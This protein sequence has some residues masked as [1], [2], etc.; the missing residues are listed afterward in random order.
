[1]ASTAFWVNA[2]AETSVGTATLAASTDTFTLTAHGLTNL[3]EVRVKSLTGGAVGVLIENAPYYVRNAAAN[4]FQ[5]AP[6]LGGPIMEFTSDGGAAV[7]RSQPVYSSQPVRRGDSG[8]LQRGNVAGGF[9]ARGGVFPQGSE[10]GHVGVSGTTWTVG[11]LVGVVS[12]A[13]GPYRVVHES[14]SNSL[15]P[16]DGTNPRLDALDLQVQDDDADGSGFHR[17]RVVYVVGTPA[18]S[19]SAPTQT[20]NSERLATILVP[21]GGSPVPSIASGPKFTTARGGIIPIL[22]STGRPTSGGLYKGLSVWDI[23]LKR[24]DINTDAGSTWE[25]LASTAG[26]TMLTGLMGRNYAHTAA[27]VTHTSDT[28]TALTG[29]P[30][31][32][33]TIP[34]GVTNALVLWGGR[35]EF[36]DSAETPL[37]RWRMQMTGANTGTVSGTSTTWAVRQA[38][39]SAGSNYQSCHSFHVQTGLSAGAT[40]FTSEYAISSGNAKFSF[41]SAFVLPFS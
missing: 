14:E 22:S 25:G 37:A 34:A 13:G 1:M 21:A 30:N 31:V 28:L 18:A 11:D 15:N 7:Y 39:G 24:L 35:V 10:T 6:T 12:A 5:L 8:L 19:P 36:T 3:D 33:V 16:A 32:T 38:T 20:T 26:F 17:A 4:T 29:G 23:A 41:R 27:E 9:G 40:T 2:A